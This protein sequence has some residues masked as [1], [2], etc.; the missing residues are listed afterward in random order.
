[1][2]EDCT[3]YRVETGMATITMQRPEAMN[4][5]NA[6]LRNELLARIRRAEEDS[7]VRVVVLTGGAKAF[8]VG[9]DLK[10]PYNPPHETVK[11]LIIEA[12]KP[13]LEA[14][15]GLTKPY[16]SAVQGPATGIGMSFGMKCDRRLMAEQ[17][18]LNQA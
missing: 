15:A 14:I 2:N 11:G 18:Y 5:F 1:M 3:R 10:E 4:A 8:S 12:Y 16:G 7:D 6:L 17:A 13:L 9:A